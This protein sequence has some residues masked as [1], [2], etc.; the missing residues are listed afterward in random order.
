MTD[1]YRGAVAVVSLL[2]E[3]DHAICEIVCQSVAVMR[4]KAYRALE[5]AGDTHGCFL[6]ATANESP[7]LCKLFGSRWW[8][9]AWTFQE[10]IVNPNTFLVGE[11]DDTLSINDALT[12]AGAIHQEAAS[13]VGYQDTVVDQ[14]ATFWH[15]VA[16]LVVASKRT[17]LLSEAMSA[18]WRRQAKE[19]HD[20]VYA[21][22]GVCHFSHIVQP[23]YA[24]PFHD[25]LRQMLNAA[26]STG[27]YS[28]MTWCAEMHHQ[29]G[30]TWAS[31]MTLVPTPELVYSVPFTGISRWISARLPSSLPELEGAKR[32]VVVPFRST[33]RIRSVSA[34]LFLS[35]AVDSLLARDYTRE[36]IWDMLFGVRV[37]LVKDISVAVG[38]RPED[39]DGDSVPLLNYAIMLINGTAKWGKSTSDMAGE[40]PFTKGITLIN[41]SAMAATAWKGGGSP[42]RLVIAETQGGVAVFLEGCGLSQ[43]SEGARIHELPIQC[44]SQASRRFVF[45]ALGSSRFAVSATGVLVPP[46]QPTGIGKWQL[47][48]IG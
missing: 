18:V 45:L 44:D 39:S 12:I 31:G 11:K 46:K 7:A 22:L 19:T 15:S 35:D 13:V 10:A 27:D 28:W 47:R 16:T 6:F 14:K 23:D 29:G 25:V 9:R 2:P 33:G 41:Y 42:R 40:R 43:T 34:P 1:I 20:L 38:N 5:Q 21:L 3:V 17:L 37:G 48:K 4:S 32:G 8:T 26:G 30:D 36:D 24:L